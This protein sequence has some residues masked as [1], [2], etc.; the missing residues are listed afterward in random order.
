MLTLKF[1]AIIYDRDRLLTIWDEP[2]CPNFSWHFFINSSFFIRFFRLKWA[3]IR[4]CSIWPAHFQSIQ[5]VFNPT[6]LLILNKQIATHH[7]FC[8]SLS[9]C[10]EITLFTDFF[11]IFSKVARFALMLKKTKQ[12]QSFQSILSQDFQLKAA[13]T[14]LFIFSAKSRNI[15]DFQLTELLCYKLMRL[16]WPWG[17]FRF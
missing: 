11:H 17:K 12:Y 10:M 16:D 1:E 13:L 5:L 7:K 2:L 14:G 9:L 4:L 15:S 3:R 8:V 6:N